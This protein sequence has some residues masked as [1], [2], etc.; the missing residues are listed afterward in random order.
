[1]PKNAAYSS[2]AQVPMLG[3]DGKYVDEKYVYEAK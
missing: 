3:N 2:P 1:M